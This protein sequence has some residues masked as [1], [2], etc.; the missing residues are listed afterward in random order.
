M[1]STLKCGS[2]SLSC[3]AF[4]RSAGSS[5]LGYGADCPLKNGFSMKGI[6]LEAII[7][8]PGLMLNEARV[9]VSASRITLE[10]E[11]ERKSSILDASIWIGS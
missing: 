6:A 1:T 10:L 7:R 11:R 2:I 3:V 4:S 9:W 5:F 8:A